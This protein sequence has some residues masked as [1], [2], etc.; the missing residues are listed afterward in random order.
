MDSLRKLTIK[1]GDSLEK[2]ALAVCRL[3]GLKRKR[4]DGNDEDDM[5]EEDRKPP[6]KKKAAQKLPTIDPKILAPLFPLPEGVTAFSLL[7]ST[8]SLYQSVWN[9]IPEAFK[10]T[11]PISD[12]RGLEKTLERILHT[13]L[14]ASSWTMA[15]DEAEEAEEN[16]DDLSESEEAGESVDNQSDAG[17][18]DSE[19][20]KQCL[21]DFD[22]DIR[23]AI[24]GLL[25]PLVDMRDCQVSSF[26]IAPDLYY[27]DE[28]AVLSP[29]A[30]EY[31]HNLHMAG[32]RLLATIRHA[33]H[34][35]YADHHDTFNHPEIDNLEYDW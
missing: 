14:D 35:L 6:K 20:R 16:N 32:C 3:G 7:R 25:G 27:N 26:G 15:K 13:H 8:I 4:G 17:T 2:K 1:A 34:T 30:M 33:R 10:T 29:E 9:K 23:D 21:F 22:E 18:E 12:F 5:A 31:G 19:D 11:V 28:K 24:K